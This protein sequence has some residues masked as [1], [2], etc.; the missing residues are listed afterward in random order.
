MW[1]DDVDPNPSSPEMMM[2]GVTIPAEVGPVDPEDTMGGNDV[3]I[4]YGGADM[5]HGGYGNDTMHG[6][7]GN[8]LMYG[9][10]GDDKIFGGEGDDII[11]GDD[12]AGPA[13]DQDTK[14]GSGEFLGLMSGK[15]KI[16]GEEGIDIIY[17]GHLAD[18]IH[19][20]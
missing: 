8:D 14:D 12:K 4:G 17:G 7:E 1:G 5:M 3:L 19:G 15:D 16:Y 20:G 18:E 6:D 10:F 2:N 11:W 13:A 9:E